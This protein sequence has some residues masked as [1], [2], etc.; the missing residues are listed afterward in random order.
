[1]HKLHL[2]FF[3]LILHTGIANA[4]QLEKDTIQSTSYSDTLT[5]IGVGDIMLGT[6][7]PY[8][9][10]LPPN[11]NCYPLLEP[12][13]HILKDAHITFGNLEGCFLDVGPVV[14]QCRDTTKCFAFKMP[15]RYVDCLVESGFDVLSL[16]N[17]HMGDFGDLG[18]ETTVRLLDSVGINH[19]GLLTHPTSTFERNG[20]KI[21]FCA[22]APNRGTCSLHDI[23]RVK[24]TV[25]KLK[26][27]ADIV[28]V[29]FHGG[30]EGAKHRHVTRE[31]EEFYGENRGNVYQFARHVIDAGADIVFGHGPHV[32]RA[33]DIYKDRFIAYSL[34]NFCT[35]GRF[36][37]SGS[38]GLAPIIKLAV[39][40]QGKF[41]EGQI[42]ATKQLGRGGVQI[43]ESKK[44]IEE[45]IW[46]TKTDIPESQL[47]I[48][49]SG[50]ITIKH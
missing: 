46:L 39:D 11:G 38:N 17:N 22:F 5:V 19:G 30:A 47:S 45:I 37:L 50:Q 3:A 14:K 21:G 24:Q 26:E 25:A 43:D 20:L 27:N 40:K 31:T 48:S 12:V 8:A 10:Y 2:L 13:K 49:P 16:A 29:S 9:S 42:I 18:R 36:N 34:G 44:V 35:Y 41:L 28:I 4:L 23:A 7:F 6:D 1:M 33:I 15:E 32:T